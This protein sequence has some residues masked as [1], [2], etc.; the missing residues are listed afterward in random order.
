MSDVGFV[1][2]GYVVIVGG[3][4]FYTVALWRRIR[5]ANAPDD[6]AR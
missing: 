5:A 1:V 3:L 4:G 6:E 2:A